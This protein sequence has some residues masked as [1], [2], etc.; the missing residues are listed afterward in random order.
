MERHIYERMAE[1]DRDHWWFVGRRR[2]VAALIDKFRPKAGPLRI[3][4]VGAGTGS[5]IEQIG[6]AHV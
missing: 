6:R 5:N 1:I 4:E 3:L 2:I